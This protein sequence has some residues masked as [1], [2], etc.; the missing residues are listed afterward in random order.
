[1]RTYTEE[2]GMKD[3]VC[4]DCVLT[5]CRVRVLRSNSVLHEHSVC[6]ADVTDERIIPQRFKHPRPDRIVFSDL[7]R[8]DPMVIQCNATNK[9]GFIWGD[10]FLNVLCKQKYFVY[11]ITCDTTSNS[12][13]CVACLSERREVGC[14]EMPL[15]NRLTSCLY[16]FFFFF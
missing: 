6:F 2:D 4:V 10:V 7:T 11:V 12:V 5:P 3:C 16:V 9:H 1:M 15:C 8:K 13:K 14:Y